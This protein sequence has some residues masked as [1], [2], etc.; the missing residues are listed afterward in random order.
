MPVSFVSRLIKG[1]F[2]RGACEA[3]PERERSDRE[4]GSEREGE[5]EGE[6]EEGRV[7]GRERERKRERERERERES[8]SERGREQVPVTDLCVGDVVQLDTGSKIP[9]GGALQS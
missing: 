3:C 4:R 1:A 5:G 6:G 9:A 2:E 8:E 7:R